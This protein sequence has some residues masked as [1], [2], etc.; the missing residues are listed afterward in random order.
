MRSALLLLGAALSA[1]ADPPP[2]KATFEEAGV[3]RITLKD[4]RAAW[5]GE[6]VDEKTLRVVQDGDLPWDIQSGLLLFPV[7]RA[8]EVWIHPTGGKAA[9][10]EGSDGGK[11][12][13]RTKSPRSVERIERDVVFDRLETADLKQIDAPD[14]PFYWMSV[15]GQLQVSSETTGWR[16]ETTV[17]LRFRS[18]RTAAVA[19]RVEILFDGEP[20][21]VAEWTG[22]APHEVEFK[23]KL[24]PEGE[25]SLEFRSEEKSAPRVIASGPS[26]TGP[27]AYLDWIELDGPRLA[28][29]PQASWIGEKGTAVIL[30][31]AQDLDVVFSRTAR[32]KRREA[33][34][35][36]GPVM[37]AS[38]TGLLRPR[39]FA[40]ARVIR[41]P[42]AKWIVVAPE[43]WKDALAPLV[44]RRAAQG[45]EPAFVAIEDVR[46]FAGCEAT[47][48]KALVSFVKAATAGEV[49]LRYLLLVGDAGRAGH[50][51][52]GSGLPRGAPGIGTGLAD[53]L[54]AGWTATDGRI[55]DP[56][57]DGK[58]DLAVGRWPARS[59]EEA[60]ALCARVARAEDA[61]AGEWRRRIHL[62]LGTAGFGKNMD[63][64]LKSGGMKLVNDLVPGSYRF[65]VQSSREL[66]LPFTWPHDD[67]NALLTRRVNEGCLVLA[68]SGHGYESGLQ[69][70]KWKGERYPILNT[71]SA[72]AL[73]PKNGLPM[74]F[75]FACLT[76][77]F[78]EPDDCLAEALARTPGGGACIVASSGI[79]HPY[80]DTIFAKELMT[81]MF[82]GGSTRIGAAVVAAKR[83]CLDPGKD[84]MR[85]FIDGMA[86]GSVGPPEVQAR[87]R[88]DGSLAYNLIGDPALRISWTGKAKLKAAKTVLR[89]EALAVTGTSELG[90]G[91]AAVELVA[92]RMKT[93]EA[94]EEP[95]EKDPDPEMLRRNWARV[96][97]AIAASAEVEMKD[98]AF[99]ARLA[100]PATLPPGRYTLRVYAA[101]GK[102]D[103]I[104]SRTVEVEEE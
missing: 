101:D 83:R 95:D 80:A 27:A 29:G 67:Y 79:S 41:L 72:K 63:S 57:A 15:P 82:E 66:Q 89:G 75:L 13:K 50:E 1:A 37:A 65:C 99:E 90:A 70:L 88:R 39:S 8:G 23:A 62:A 92:E 14:A 53:A 100:L 3:A 42:A 87:Y 76:G 45:L 10:E 12:A 18:M 56:D 86:A 4:L 31:D 30:S 69:S 20:A 61:P 43:R 64:M 74:I 36:E 93:V 52:T 97:E 81:A 85:Q 48:E 25:L 78:D 33:L 17:R 2:L 22:G 58:P 71:E 16:R 84:P 38:L 9:V 96:N 44:E 54:G 32:L 47:D 28:Q 5:S 59:A 6:T 51:A 26:G 40:P 35:A 102:A 21:A 77:A 7:P 68:Y 11:D 104:G 103:A 73:D 24:S 98:G 49:K 91:R 55:A 94:M 34:G 46:D 60:A 19:H